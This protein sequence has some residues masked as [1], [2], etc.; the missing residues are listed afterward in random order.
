MNEEIITSFYKLKI[1]CEKEQ[2]KGWDPYD[3]LNSSLFNS[4]P[5]IKSNRFSK[6][7]WIQFFKRSPVNIRQV[8]GV[9]KDFNSKGLGLFVSGYC[10][11]YKQD[12]QQAELDKIVLLTN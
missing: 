10:N 5:F 7:A 1:Y 3:G 9:K 2:Y 8:F 12:M 6:L 11:L 4:L